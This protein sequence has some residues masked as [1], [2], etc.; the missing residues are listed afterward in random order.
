MKTTFYSSCPL[1]R[2]GSFLTFLYLIM[3]LDRVGGVSYCLACPSWLLN[4]CNMFHITMFYRCQWD[5]SHTLNRKELLAGH[6]TSSKEQM[7]HIFRR[8][9]CALRG[10]TLPSDCV[11]QMLHDVNELTWRDEREARLWYH[12]QLIGCYV[13]IVCLH[14][15]L[16][17]YVHD[18][19]EIL[20]RNSFKGVECNNL[21]I[22]FL[23]F[24]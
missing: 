18:D 1:G 6:G 10:K 15:S 21:K 7:S 17:P 9:E 3:I 12:H 24:K 8:K 16:F 4:M 22:F 2:T 13:L 5:S 11:F 20:G 14:T 19:C 23:L